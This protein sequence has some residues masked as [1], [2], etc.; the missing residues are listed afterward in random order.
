VCLMSNGLIP[1]ALPGELE[2]RVEVFG[3]DVRNHPV[4]ELATKVGIVFQEPESQLFSMSVEEEVAFGPENL[5]IPREE[6]R[7]RVEWALEIVGMK[8]YNDRTPFSLS[9]GQKQRVAIAAALSMHPEMLVL[10]EPAYALDPL[11]RAELYTVL[12]D[13][14]TRHG[15]TILLAER[16]AEEAA[17]FSDRI[18][19]MSEGRIIEIGTPKTILKEPERLRSIGLEPTQLALVAS[20]LNA[21]LGRSDLSFLSVDEAERTISKLIE[22]GSRRGSV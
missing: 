21:E 4:A 10:D 7:E 6:I 2:G 3:L 19:L 22:T 18:A 12:S 15:V 1:H 20:L 14:K 16:D 8:G 5:A 9:G 11:G 13:L 17:V